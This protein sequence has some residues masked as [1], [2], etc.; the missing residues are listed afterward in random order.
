MPEHALNADVVAAL[1]SFTTMMGTLN[2]TMQG[3]NTSVEGQSTAMAG[4][5]AN[6]KATLTL[7]AANSSVEMECSTMG[8][9]VVAIRGT[10]TG[11]IAVYGSS[12]PSTVTGRTLGGRL[13]FKSGIGSN[14]TNRVVGTGAAM[15]REFRLT[16][17]G[18]YVVFQAS[19]DFSGSATI[20]VEATRSASTVFVNGPTHGSF[21]EALR[22]GRAYSVSTGVVSVPVGSYLN[23]I[24]TNPAS[25][26]TNA[27]LAVHTFSTDLAAPASIT[28]KVNP[29]AIT[30]PTMVSPVNLKTGGN[31]S[32]CTLATKTETT[33]LAGS[34][35]TGQLLIPGNGFEYKNDLMRIIPPGQSFGFSIGGAGGVLASAAKIS[36]SLAFWEEVA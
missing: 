12:D 23:Y 20:V 36:A 7:N 33:A 21:E 2:S 22:D 30:S 11:S 14:G 17:G 28:Q 5:S 31:T 24:F 1:D 13:I 29:T 10:F 3:V 27:I 34:G 25:A 15:S 32:S 6:K 18:G 9:A 35:A 19:A 4:S 16:L 26:T 8:S